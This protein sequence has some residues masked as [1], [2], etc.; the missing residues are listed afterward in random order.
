MSST[1]RP[2]SPLPSADSVKQAPVLGSSQG[3]PSI[4]QPSAPKFK[5][6]DENV[7]SL[8]PDDNCPQENNHMYGFFC[9][10]C[11]S[12]PM[13]WGAELPSFEGKDG[14]IMT[15][16]PSGGIV[17]GVQLQDNEAIA[18]LSTVVFVDVRGWR[19]SEI[20][21]LIP[22]MDK[23]PKSVSAGQCIAVI[24]LTIL[25]SA[26]NEE[27][28]A[29][30]EFWEIVN[31]AL[32]MPFMSAKKYV[33]KTLSTLQ[34]FQGLPARAK[35]EIPFPAFDFQTTSLVEHQEQ[36][37]SPKDDLDWKK[38]HLRSQGETHGP[39]PPGKW[40]F[41]D[42]TDLSKAILGKPEPHKWFIV[43]QDIDDLDKMD[44]REYP[45]IRG[46]DWNDPND[47]KALNKNR[48]QIIDRT[49]P[50]D[51]E[52]SRPPWTKLEKT[53]LEELI[54]HDL[55]SGKTKYSLD[56][57]D[58][59]TRLEKRFES[60]RQKAGVSLA[61]TSKMIKRQ[62]VFPLK[63]DPKLAKDRLG[64]AKRAESAVRTQAMKYHDLVALING[65]S[66]SDNGTSP[67]TRGSHKAEDL[68]V[69]Q[70]LTDDD[71][72]DSEDRGDRN[73]PHEA[74]ED[75]KKSKKRKL[76]ETAEE[77]EIGY[78]G[79][80]GNNNDGEYVENASKPKKRRKTPKKA[81]Q[82]PQ[83]NPPR[84]ATR[85]RDPPPPPPPSSASAFT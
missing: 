22:L 58:I 64:P 48:K 81:V 83:R 14:K 74:R 42:G 63:K 56:W 32:L 69:D 43:R 28:D 53:V 52:D 60:V 34:K 10:T 79:D 31:I 57:K 29:I 23:H 65:S 72:V 68:A 38:R 44:V 71:A 62:M 41:A 55:E 82:S 54:R 21:G 18:V 59:A 46:F 36:E 2:S 37:S 50:S 76:G 80:S 45:G 17:D 1:T 40:K 19:Y 73:E 84:T 30:P 13:E 4:G 70:V 9:G 47:I 35:P 5:T 51:A 15:T 20:P 26:R 66:Q 49:N 67:S 27:E 16:G 75:T 39:A 24:Y 25:R 85:R 12:I 11:R 6:P 78:F 7:I 61:Q 3:Q 33:I 8:V 77:D